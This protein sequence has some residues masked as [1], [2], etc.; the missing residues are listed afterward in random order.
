[1]LV[2]AV[3]FCTRGFLSEG[4]FKFIMI[5]I[6]YLYY[7]VCE[8]TT[9]KTVGKFLTKTAVVDAKS[10]DEPH[11][12]QILFRTLLRMVPIDFISYLFSEQGIHDSLSKTKLKL[13]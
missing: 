11:I 9:G 2:V 10:G 1:M 7:F 12:G 13:N 3:G 4:Q 8:A 5:L 6:Y